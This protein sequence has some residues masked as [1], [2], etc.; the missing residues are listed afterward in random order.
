MKRIILAA[1]LLAC[2]F[3][4]A[5]CGFLNNDNDDTSNDTSA[6]TTAPT[7]APADTET[8]TDAPADASPTAPST[9]TSDTNGPVVASLAQLSATIMAAGQFW[10]D[11]WAFEG[12]FTFTDGYGIFVATDPDF[13]GTGMSF[14]PLLPA[15]GFS[16]LEDV[17]SYLSQYYSAHLAESEMAHIFIMYEGVLHFANARAGFPRFDWTDA[18]FELV[19]EINGATVV[20]ATVRHGYFILDPGGYV[21]LRFYMVD[22]RIDYVSGGSIVTA[23][24]DWW[25]SDGAG[26]YE[27]WDTLTLELAGGWLYV[28][29]AAESLL[30]SFID[31]HTVNHS[32][33][34]GGE[35]ENWGDRLV[36]WSTMPLFDLE[37]I[38]VVTDWFD[39]SL[40][41]I[42]TVNYGRMDALW[43]GE[44]YIIANYVSM[45]TLPW[46]GITFLDGDGTRY[47]FWLNHDQSDSANRFSL[48][49]FTDRTDELPDDWDRWWLD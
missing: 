26:D 25:G 7:E 28:A 14:S 1:A 29:T 37:L 5:G 21:T 8:P 47:H 20:E 18:T 45:G 44:G 3:F 43:P 19:E 48:G 32:H 27:V 15:S 12:I 13:P 22:G 16:N 24:L 4:V 6:Q 38:G 9:D 40:I 39:E 30:G 36:I 34:H 10:E 42:P 23:T 49:Q 46:S 35:N 41:F 33:L 11:W 2:I 17:R 31:L